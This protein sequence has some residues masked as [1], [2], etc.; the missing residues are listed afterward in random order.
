MT[1]RVAPVAVSP[2]P[3]S[4]LSTRRPRET[5]GRPAGTGANR[6]LAGLWPGPRGASVGRIVALA[7]SGRARRVRDALPPIAPSRLA[8]PAPAVEPVPTTTV[9]A[10][11]TLTRFTPRVRG[12][13]KAHR[14][15]EQICLHPH[16]AQRL[17]AG[18]SF[19]QARIDEERVA[20][21]YL[22]QLQ[23]G[24]SATI[25][26]F[27]AYFSDGDGDATDLPDAV[28]QALQLA[29]TQG[30][31]AIAARDEVM[32]CGSEDVASVAS[33]KDMAAQ[34]AGSS[35]YNLSHALFVHRDG[36]LQLLAD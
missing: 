5:A 29:L 14:L 26:K 22:A 27:V 18:L 9:E 20:Q 25:E 15:I 7:R 4:R 8:L 19:H 35:A 30:F 28:A 24:G 3:R 6:A 21:E 34:I 33:L 11:I 1:P 32:V 12:L 36:E 2:R 23:A 13:A 17:D 31:D 16:Q 10:T